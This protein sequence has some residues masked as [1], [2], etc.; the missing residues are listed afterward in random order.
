MKI[1][2]T[3]ILLVTVFV[4]RA[5]FLDQLVISD[6]AFKTE[7]LRMIEIPFEAKI[8]GES[9]FNSIPYSDDEGFIYMNFPDSLIVLYCGSNHN[10]FKISERLKVSQV[11]RENNLIIRTNSDSREEVIVKVVNKPE[12]AIQFYFP[13]TALDMGGR[14]Q[15]MAFEFTNLKK[16]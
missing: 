14:K 2:L 15:M 7:K 16:L 12:I 3:L 10:S 5:Q 8:I 4:G 11:K 13:E 9:S 6:H 1:H